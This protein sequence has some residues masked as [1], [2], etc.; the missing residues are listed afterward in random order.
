MDFQER[1]HRAA[2]RGRQARDEKARAEAAVAMS[3]EECRRRHA[4]LRHDLNDH[5]EACLKQLADNFPGFHYEPVVT[6]R[7]WGGAVRRDDL[8]IA[9]GRRENLFSRLEMVV[10]P[11]NKYHVLDVVAKGAV[12]NKEN[13]TRNHYQA[14]REANLDRFREL[15]EQWTLDYAEQ[16]AAAE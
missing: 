2:E 11:H 9:D 3:E 14:L 15:I 8:A 13:F 4:S 12:R 16:Y 5:I 10:S 6:E 1:L 7:G